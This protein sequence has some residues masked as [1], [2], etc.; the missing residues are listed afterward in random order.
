VCYERRQGDSVG[1]HAKAHSWTKQ[2]GCHTIGRRGTAVYTMHA[3]TQKRAQSLFVYL[4]TQEPSPPLY[5]RPSST[6][7]LRIPRGR[8]HSTQFF[9][10][11]HHPNNTQTGK[12]PDNRRHII[13]A[14]HTKTPSFE[15]AKVRLHY[16]ENKKRNVATALGR[17]KARGPQLRKR[18]RRRDESVEGITWCSPRDSFANRIR[19]A[20]T[21]RYTS[22]RVHSEVSG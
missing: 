2:P 18:T 17:T 7:T 16:L 11:R 21:R 22:A 6:T 9:R 4:E 12:L 3:H 10:H 15:E 14:Y 1:G 20:H 13:F 8:K 5:T 19:K